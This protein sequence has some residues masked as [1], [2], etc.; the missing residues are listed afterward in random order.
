MKRAWFL[1][2]MVCA[3]VVSVCAQEAVWT[4]EDSL[5]LQQMLKGEG[6][7]ELNQ[8]ALEE[9]RRQTFLEEEP[10]MSEEKPWMEFDE[11]LPVLPGMPPKPKFMMTLRP[12]TPTTPYNWDPVRQEKI[13]IDKALRGTFSHLTELKIPTDWAENP[14]DAGPRKTVEQIE[15]TGLRYRMTERANGMV[16]GSWQPASGGG[17][18]D[19]MRIFTRDFWSFRK[20]KRRA[21]TLEVI[22]AY[23]DSLTLRNDRGK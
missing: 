14:L 7:V 11:T 4:A 20:R 3:S 16:V 5:R 8:E 21:K 2:G 9:F 15:A 10:Q 18:L 22:Q 6:E 1:G 17:S 19:M 23:G 12:Y 13:D